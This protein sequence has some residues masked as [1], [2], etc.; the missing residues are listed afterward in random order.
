MSAA[1]APET[2]AGRYVRGASPSCA[3]SFAD[4]GRWARP[5]EG[6]AA[7]ERREGTA[8]KWPGERALWRWEPYAWDSPGTSSWPTPD[9]P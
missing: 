9:G 6:A 5:A 4:E 3:P 2:Q 8:P 7:P 1:A